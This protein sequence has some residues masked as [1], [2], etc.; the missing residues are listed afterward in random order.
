MIASPC[1]HRWSR[2]ELGAVRSDADGVRRL[3][4]QARDQGSERG[5]LETGKRVG[6]RRSLGEAVVERPSGDRAGGDGFFI[7]RT[8]WLRCGAGVVGRGAGRIGLRRLRVHRGAG[9]CARQLV[10]CRRVDPPEQ[11]ARLDRAV[12]RV[13]DV[14]R[15]VAS[16][17]RNY[18]AIGQVWGNCTWYRK[19]IRT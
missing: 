14:E 9:A 19:P 18:I 5:G 6:V 16:S 2:G 1:C 7:V 17:L 13:A 11:I 4:V 10:P 15:R 12:A 8:R 3:A